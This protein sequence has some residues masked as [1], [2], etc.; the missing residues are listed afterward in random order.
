[1]SPYRDSTVTT[2]STL[3]LIE[4]RLPQGFQ[5]TRGQKEIRLGTREQ[6]HVYGSGQT[7]IEEIL[8]GNTGTRGKFCWEQGNTAGHPLEGPHRGSVLQNTMIARDGAIAWTKIL[9]A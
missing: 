5:G 9:K 7:K 1:M 6:K 2:R 4:G 3:L 8:L